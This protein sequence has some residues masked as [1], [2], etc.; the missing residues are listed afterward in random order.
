MKRAMKLSDTDNVA[1]LLDDIS[2]G[3]TAV[4]LDADKKELGQITVLSDIRRG[5]KT[6]VTDIPSG[7]LILKY[8]Q[9][10]GGASCDI[11]A[12]ELVHTHN[13]ESLRGRGDRI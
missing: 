3:E 1:T 5:H 10:I 13:L 7:T 4:I 11:K 6:A 9:I 8:G 2:C 12:G